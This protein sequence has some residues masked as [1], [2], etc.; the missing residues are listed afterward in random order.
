MK[1]EC[2]VNN[3]VLVYDRKLEEIFDTGEIR[4]KIELS[5]SDK[6]LGVGVTEL[7]NFK[8]VFT[9]QELQLQAIAQDKRL[10]VAENK[11]NKTD[12]IDNDFV[13]LV[14]TLAQFLESKGAAI[15]QFGFNFSFAFKDTEFETISEKV[16]TKFF[17]EDVVVTDGSL[18]YYLPNYSYTEDGKR[19]T[20][21][22][23][24]E[25]NEAGEPV[26]ITI[27]TNIHMNSTFPV[28]ALALSSL[29]QES[30]TKLRDLM[31]I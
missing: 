11:I 27:A 26:R 31:V 15:S 10:V 28:D 12:E 19:Y 17:K 13:K 9:T 25:P 5:R 2:L 3:V 24:T 14:S 6:E 22:Y 23:D 1:P 18:N 29:Y 16:R 20:I 4:K 7:N 8:A 30:Y 21:K